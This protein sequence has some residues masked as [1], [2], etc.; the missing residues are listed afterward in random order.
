MKA[1]NFRWIPSTCICIYIASAAFATDVAAQGYI[2]FANRIP[3]QLIAPIFGG[4]PN[5]PATIL[6]GNPTNGLPVGVTVYHGLRLEGAG[7]TAE[8][9]AGPTENQLFPVATT[10]FLTGANA[11]FVQSST[12]V[13]P[14]VGPGGQAWIQ[15]RVWKNVGGTFPTWFSLAAGGSVPRG[16]SPV[17][18]VTTGSTGPSAATIPPLRSFNITCLSCGAR[19][20]VS[21]LSGAVNSAPGE[22]VTFLMNSFGELPVT[23]QWLFNGV[24]LQSSPFI[25][26]TTSG[27]GS[28]VPTHSLILSNVQ[29]AQAGQYSLAASND[30]GV[31]VSSNTTLTVFPPP[32][33]VAPRITTEGKFSLLLTGA[34]SRR[35]SI[36]TSSNLSSWLPSTTVT[37]LS[38]QVSFTEDIS[39]ADAARYF[40]ARLLP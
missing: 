30:F 32:F 38:G 7:Y 21:Q 29:P 27:S 3:G 8:L 13:I 33:L 5:N 19:P 36:E 4:E 23:Y 24:P 6:Q 20:F 18:I 16:L 39:A 1:E 2:L 31:Y 11:G 26:Q 40:R 9:W 28:G 34:P 14:S 37:N 10:T 35:Y 22:T 12:V 17:M 25:T 15:W